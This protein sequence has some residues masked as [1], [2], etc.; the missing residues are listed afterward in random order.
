MARTRG[1]L[2][3]RPLS[4][5]RELAAGGPPYPRGLLTAL[6]NDQ[7]RGARALHETC[8]RALDRRRRV[9][10]RFKAM[11]EYENKAFD[12]GFRRVAGVDEAGRGPLAGPIV[13]AAVILREPVPGV[14]D[15]KKLL[16][17]EREALY[18]ELMA[19]THWIAAE[20]ISHDVI[21]QLGIQT[22]N[23]MALANAAAKLE[24]PADFLLVDG[25]KVP[26]CPTPHERI[27]K[28]DSLS[29]SIAAASII[30]KVTRDRIMLEYDAR[31]P[32]YGFRHH[33]GYT[34]RE[35]LAAL[36][37]YGPCPIHRK[38]FAPVAMNGQITLDF[39]TTTKDEVECELS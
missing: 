17:D 32:E 16:P 21:D 30:A 24:P 25:F 7:R 36:D 31:Y 6:R 9:N 29:Q 39:T 38:S 28:G 19:G 4:E 34:T 33:K 11:W 13:G 15:S 14:D 23:Y 27:V 26:G 22:A 35:H 20:I 37:A 5:L 1:A 12:N 10:A 18:A 2:K 3:E 8:L